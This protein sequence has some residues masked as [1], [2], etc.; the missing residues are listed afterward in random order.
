M[1]Q[2]YQAPTS[3]SP[4]EISITIFSGTRITKLSWFY[5]K[6]TK[7]IGFLIWC[8]GIWLQHY[9]ITKT[10]MLLTLSFRN[11]GFENF[12]YLGY[13]KKYPVPLRLEL[14]KSEYWN[15]IGH[16]MNFQ[17]RSANDFNVACAYQQCTSVHGITNFWTTNTL[18]WDKIVVSWSTVVFLGRTDQIILTTKIW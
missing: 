14:V 6:I 5:D 7:K 2:C 4:A 12:L 13:P 18:N 1:S 3:R 17:V 10:T 15:I 11:Y 8:L 16:H 9:C